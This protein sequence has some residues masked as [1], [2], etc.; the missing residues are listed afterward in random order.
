MNLRRRDD[1]LR[2]LRA[3]PGFNAF[4]LVIVALYSCDQSCDDTLGGPDDRADAPYTVELVPD[5]IVLE[6]GETRSVTALLSSTDPATVEFTTDDARV[7]VVDNAD[8]GRTGTVTGVALGE[9]L[10]YGRGPGNA[11]NGI[12]SPSARVRVVPTRVVPEIDPDELEMEPGQSARLRCIVKRPSTGEVVA[13][14][15]VT[16]SSSSGRVARVAPDGTVTALE[17]GIATITCS[18]PTGESDQATVFVDTDAT[19]RISPRSLELFVGQTAPLTCTITHAVTGQVLT[20]RPLVWSSTNQAIA[21]VDA[22]GRVLAVAPGSTTIVCRSGNLLDSIVVTVLEPPD[23][24]VIAGDYALSASK[25]SDTC[26]A[27]NFSGSITNPRI[28][29]EVVN[30]SG[31]VFIRIV[32]TPE[33]VGEYDTATG[34]FRGTGRLNA[35]S[36]LLGK[37]VTGGFRANPVRLDGTLSLSRLASDGSKA[38]EARYNASYVKLK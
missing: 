24:S 18:L 17:D 14:Q 30:S 8:R 28:A 4:M 23:P 2:L 1:D 31:H 10:I 6:V 25:V 12:A 33:V 13:G 11:P 38:C 19:A 5:P 3:R 35:G 16:W 21:T 37:E 15:Q 20:G 34:A 29:I 32:S 22:S 7:A 26:P 9:T 27:G 36:V